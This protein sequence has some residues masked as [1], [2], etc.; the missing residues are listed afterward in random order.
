[1]NHLLFLFLLWFQSGAA[2][3]HFREGVAALRAGD[4]SQAIAH[5][6]HVRESGIT[7]GALELNLALAHL[8]IDSLGMAAY[9]FRLAGRHPET[10]DLANQGLVHVS[11]NLARRSPGLP[12]LGLNRF[13]NRLLSEFPLQRLALAAAGMFLLGM[14]L[15][16]AQVVNPVAARWPR[17]IAWSGMA[18][19]GA[20]LVAAVGVELARVRHPIGLVVVREVPLRNGPDPAAATDLNAF[21]GYEVRVDRGRSTPQWTHI[22]LLNGSDGWVPAGVVRIF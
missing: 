12:V 19:A 18:L 8:R 21:E 5:F 15:R 7:S 11:E 4:A 22:T 14:G 16:I 20:L 2:D 9:H 6:N 1:M 10:T 3:D 13:L 17:W